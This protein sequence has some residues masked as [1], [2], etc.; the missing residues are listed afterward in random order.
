MIFSVVAR[1]S[2]VFLALGPVQTRQV[3]GGQNPKAS[4]RALLS[5]QQVFLRQPAF[6]WLER[7]LPC[8]QA[9]LP[10]AHLLSASGDGQ[11][12]VLAALQYCRCP[13]ET[14]QGKVVALDGWVQAVVVCLEPLAPLAH[15][16]LA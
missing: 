4:E 11:A 2:E 8:C 1:L 9:F 12:Q 10:F 7:L 14:V 15:L 5:L 16:N 3:F 13:S 6:W